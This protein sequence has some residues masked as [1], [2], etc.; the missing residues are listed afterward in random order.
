MKP[1]DPRKQYGK[2]LLIKP[3]IISPKSL[4]PPLISAS[5][6]VSHEEAQEKK[7]RS[8]NEETTKKSVVMEGMPKLSQANMEDVDAKS[9]KGKDSDDDSSSEELKIGAN[10]KPIS[11]PPTI[12]T[13]PNVN[14]ER[15]LQ[16]RLPI[17]Q[18]PITTTGQTITKPG[19][20]N[21]PATN[22]TVQANQVLKSGPDMKEFLTNHK[23]EADS[24][25]DEWHIK[26]DN[27]AK[28]QENSRK[29]A[30]IQLKLQQ[31]RQ[32]APRPQQ[33]DA[34]NQDFQLSS[35]QSR[36]PVQRLA[37]QLAQGAPKRQAAQHRK[38]SND[39]NSWD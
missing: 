26:G 38:G 16:I 18:P 10:R 22:T 4:A 12:T 29:P 14:T 23:N 32:Q 34:K 1:G 2:P 24:D 36:V 33:E 30:T 5:P 21:I 7:L 28:Q 20:E 6:S 11:H 31:Q 9:S 19:Q 25:E 37:P 3:G 13:Q 8:S 27:Q 35:P 17:S 15:K 39:S